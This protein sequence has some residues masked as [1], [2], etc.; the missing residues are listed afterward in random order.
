M[1]EGIFRFANSIRW[2]AQAYD[3]LV[4]SKTGLRGRAWAIYGKGCRLGWKLIGKS[5]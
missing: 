2:N 1:M 5:R 3:V 4:I